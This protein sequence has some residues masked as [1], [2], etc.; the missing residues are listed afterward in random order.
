MHPA[1]NA[2]APVGLSERIGAIDVARGVAL[3]GILFV[4]IHY[5]GESSGIYFASRPPADATPIS[6][7]AWYLYHVLC[8][9][10]FY[11]LFSMLFGAG[12][13]IQFDRARQ[14]SSSWILTPIRRLLTLLFIGIAHALL[15]WYGD[16]LVTYAI[17]GFWMILFARLPLK[18]L[19]IVAS[20]L[21]FVSL[22]FLLLTVV[23]TAFGGHYSQQ[24]PVSEFVLDSRPPL[25]QLVDGLMR[26][27]LTGPWDAAWQ[28]LEARAMRDGPYG[29]AFGMRAITWGITAA[30]TLFAGGTQILL[31][32]VIGAILVRTGFFLPTNS[33][34]HRRFAIGGLV[35]GLPAAIISAIASPFQAQTWGTAVYAFM[36][37][38]GGPVLSLGYLGCI[39]LWANSD[40]ATVLQ[41]IFANTG[42][43]GLTSYLLCSILGTA[44]FYHWGLGWV[45]ETTVAQRLVFAIVVYAIVAAFASF[46]LRSFAFG[47]VEWF[48]RSMTYLRFPPLLKR[49]TEPATT[50]AA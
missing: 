42:R 21:L 34:W 40:R 22:T 18:W 14:R 10:K 31:L 28:E 45:G 36:Q 49:E 17:L 16:I 3:L 25:D 20:F 38:F 19:G 46:W 24:K 41:R 8:E 7:A 1:T 15:V 12:L 39:M 37:T 13:A 9:A 2:L 43:M 11:P 35:L 5:M 4:N 50:L 6:S 30:F 26:R 48:W 44:I 47:P 33:L 27:T 32:F 29:Q 23:S